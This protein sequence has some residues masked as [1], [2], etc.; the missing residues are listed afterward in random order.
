MGLRVVGDEGSVEYEPASIEE[1]AQ[2][3]LAATRKLERLM[4]I[5]RL[6]GTETLKSISYSS[7]NAAVS[8]FE[9]LAEDR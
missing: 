9:H 7:V 3:A 5:E 2:D 1:A 8:V 6:N 4:L